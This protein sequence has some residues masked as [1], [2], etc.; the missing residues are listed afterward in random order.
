MGRR[1]STRLRFWGRGRSGAGA[2]VG[3][4]VSQFA[5]RRGSGGGSFWVAWVLGS[6]DWG[7]GLLGGGGSFINGQSR[8]DCPTQQSLVSLGCGEGVCDFQD[9]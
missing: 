7:V 1:W 8:R 3:F 9:C 4:S 6:G 2:L 5:D